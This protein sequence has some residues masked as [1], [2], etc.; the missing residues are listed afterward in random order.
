MG[1]CCFSTFS[2]AISFLCC[3][4]ASTRNSTEVTYCIA[5]PGNKDLDED[6]DIAEISEY[7]QSSSHRQK[8]VRMTTRGSS[9]PSPAWSPCRPPGRRRWWG[10][11]CRRP[12]P[13]SGQRRSIAAP[14]HMVLVSTTTTTVVRYSKYSPWLCSTRRCR[15]GTSGSARWRSTCRWSRAWR[16]TASPRKTLKNKKHYSSKHNRYRGYIWNQNRLNIFMH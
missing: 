10:R 3:T 4:L 14:G 2:R 7:L 6:S 5:T 15:G 16:R 11:P 13:P 1:Y 9:A 8:R 12:Q